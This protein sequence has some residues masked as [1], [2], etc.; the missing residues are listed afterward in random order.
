[1][2][3]RKAF[4]LTTSLKRH[5]KTRA[6]VAIEGERREAWLHAGILVRITNESLESGKFFQPRGLV[7]K[8]VDDFLAEIELDDG[9]L[10]MIDQQE[11]ETIPRRAR[12]SSSS[13]VPVEGTR[14]RFFR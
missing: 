12:R 8:V 2:E 14:R 3:K 5:L 1:M 9:A 7:R 13:T 11:L 4:F 10:V 6:A